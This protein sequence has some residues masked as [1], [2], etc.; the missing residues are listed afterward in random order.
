LSH[1][2]VW[3]LKQVAEQLNKEIHSPDMQNF[4]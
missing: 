2:P 1:I 4:V 3:M